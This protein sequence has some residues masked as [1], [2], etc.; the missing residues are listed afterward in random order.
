LWHYGVLHTALHGHVVAWIDQRLELAK[1]KRNAI[2]CD[3]W[4]PIWQRTMPNEHG[5]Q[6][7]GLRQSHTIVQVA[8]KV[9][10]HEKRRVQLYGSQV[11]CQLSVLISY[12]YTG[13]YVCRK[14]RAPSR[15]VVNR[16]V[17]DPSPD[18]SSED[19]CRIGHVC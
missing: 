13:W 5:H 11:D 15:A 3:C 6:I 2:A 8:F 1:R 12:R 10:I 14:E 9:D 17:E 16:G 4:L 7:G 18:G 19:H